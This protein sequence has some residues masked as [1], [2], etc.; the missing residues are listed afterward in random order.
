M[1]IN[2]IDMI[3]GWW[4]VWNIVWMNVVEFFVIDLFKGGECLIILL[5]YFIVVI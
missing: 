2:F 3:G 5:F 1:G 4:K